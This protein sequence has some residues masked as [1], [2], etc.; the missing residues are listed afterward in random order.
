MRYLKNKFSWISG[1]LTVVLLLN[2]LFLYAQDDPGGTPGG[3]CDPFTDPNC[4]PEDA[5]LDNWVFVLVFLVIAL[6][7]WYYYK[8][9]KSLRAL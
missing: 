5:P 3:G 2:T 9:K 4:N 7:I 6:T 8:Q 1:I